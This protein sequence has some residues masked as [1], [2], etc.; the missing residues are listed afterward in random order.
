MN[1]FIYYAI[2]RY[3][4]TWL[5]GK[6]VSQLQ[7]TTSKWLQVIYGYII[8]R[9]TGGRLSIAFYTALFLAAFVGLCEIG[10]LAGEIWVSYLDATTPQSCTYDHSVDG[11]YSVP[12]FHRRDS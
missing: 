5:M 11:L 1:I 2:L 7:D 3:F 6:R 12:L 10:S 4:L 9:P 8:N